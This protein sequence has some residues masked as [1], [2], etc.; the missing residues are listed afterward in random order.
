MTKI[1][2]YALFAATVILIL[3][4][5]V[6]GFLQ[7]QQGLART[8]L[9]EPVV[10]GLYVVCF[11]FFT[12]VGAGGLFV[13]SLILCSGREEYQPLARPGAIVSLVSLMLAGM[14]ITI[15]LGRPE[16]AHL[17]MLKPQLT[18]PLIWDFFILNTMLGIGAIYTLF[19]MRRDVLSGERRCGLISHLLGIGG[20][21]GGDKT[22]VP[23]LIRMLAGIMVIGIPILYLLTVRV[24]ASLR[25][26]P[27]WNT[28]ILGPVF[29]VS[30]IVS[31]VA[32]ICIVAGVC[33][34]TQQQTDHTTRMWGAVRNALIILIAIDIIL[35]L[36][37]LVTMRQFDSPSRLTIWSEIGCIAAVE[38]LIGMIV[39]LIILL[40][41]RKNLQR[42]SVVV[43]M[44][45]LLGVFA[46]RWGV[47]IPAM[48][49]RSLPLPSAS[50]QPSAVE[51]GRA[52]V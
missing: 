46:K 29:L 14:F 37:P 39:P 22:H 35:T 12:G 16:L 48:L 42:W 49:Q 18:S 34:K 44:L 6:A 9:H 25:A 8:N 33:R 40:T 28:T 51:I 11:V 4:G 36:S 30:A 31:G 21:S 47:I 15:D 26:K 41:A 1:A 23:T 27:D 32:A 3:T 17:L 20:K 45:I 19:V 38:L 13:T 10:W 2:R 43:G 50:Y 24:F 7:L 52:H 5:A